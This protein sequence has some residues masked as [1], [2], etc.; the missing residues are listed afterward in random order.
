MKSFKKYLFKY[1]PMYLI[2]F[3]SLVVGI[4]L[5]LAAPLFIKELIDKVIRGGQTQLLMKLLYPLLF[6]GIGRAFFIYTKEML[7]DVVGISVAVD[8]RRDIFSHLLKLPLRFFKKY[9]TGQLMA[10]VK[11][12]VDKIWNA[13]GFVGM[14]SV[15]C[16][17]HCI[18]CIIFMARINIFL[19]LIPIAFM[20]IIAYHAL[21][22]EKKLNDIY[23]DI[24]EE[25]AALTTIAQENIG[26]VRTVKAFAR[27]K[28][29]I[30]KFLDHNDNFYKLHVKQANTV[31]RYQPNIQFLTKFLLLLVIS[32]G[33]IFVVKEWITLGDL[34]A[35]TDYATNLI[36]PMEL[37]GWLAG[38]IAAASASISKLNKIR[39]EKSEILSPEH[40]ITKE[41]IQ[42]D[43]EF[44]N[45]SFSIDDTK[46]LQNVSFHLS[47]GKTIG[48]MG[49]TGS[50][51]SSITNLIERFYDVND[52]EILLDGVNIKDYD[53][54]AL[55]EQISIVMQ[56][57]FLFSDSVEENLRIGQKASLESEKLHLAAN[58]ARASGFIEDLSNGY[59][60]IIG[61]RGVGLSG[62]QRQRLSIARAFAKESPI[63]IL[64]DS[65]SALDMETEHD[66]QM[67]LK[68]LPHSSKVII[69]HRISAVV[70]ADEIIILEN[71]KIVE[72]GTHHTLLKEKG[73]Y[74]ET[75]QSQY[76]TY[77]EREVNV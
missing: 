48:I 75:Y 29:E 40:P 67:S 15:E 58:Y 50:G 30:Q 77:R 71:G 38:D 27:E 5:D 51:K 37:I 72:R 39:E 73:K 76:Q 13:A 64:D 70:E 14:L 65:T 34:G 10:R 49:S 32:V 56:D 41:H 16:V 53:L 21:R 7:F 31:A 60:T 69:A 11:D 24:S 68:K 55:R 43:L 62:G 2:A 63:L 17:I 6:I 59:E 46:I 8:M 26:G 57:V 28:Y 12:D 35:F 9:N 42:G 36:W 19:T 3:I 47:P 1:W 18:L 52:G 66:I 44:R 33:G 20:P 22:L 4:L 25:N 54:A 61:E 23:Q 74:Y 45:V